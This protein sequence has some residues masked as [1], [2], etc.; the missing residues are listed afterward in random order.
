MR[1][2]SLY[3]RAVFENVANGTGHTV[4]NACAGS[5]K[6]LGLGT[7]VMLH[8]GSIKPVEQIAAGDSLMGPD[9]EPRIVQ[10]VSRGNGP[11]FRIVPVKGDPWICNDAHILTLTGTNRHVNEVRDVALCDLLAE[12]GERRID[13]DWKLWRT[14]VRF[15]SQAVTVDPY[16]VGLWLGDGTRGEAQITNREPEIISYCQ[17]IAAKYGHECVLRPDESHNTVNIRFRIGERGEAGRH[18]PSVLRR[19][20]SERCE[21]SGYK[22]MPREYVFNDEQVRF[23]ILAGLLDTDGYYAGG[24]YEWVTVSHTLAEQMLFL[25]R[26]LGLAAYAFDKTVNGVVYKRLSISGDLSR[27]PVRVPRRMV[28]SRKQIKRATVT[29]FTVEYIGRGDYYGFTLDGDGRFLL[30]DFTVTHNTT[31][32]EAA[33]E[34]VPSGLKTLFVAFNKAIA[35]ELGRRVRG[36]GV[37]VSTLHSYGL[38]CVTAALG[39]LR[40]DGRR[41]DDFCRA[42]HGDDSKTWELRRDLAKTVSLCKGALASTEE[43]VDEIIDAFGIGSAVNGNRAPF[44]QD[45][46]KLLQQCTGTDDGRIDF[47]DMIWLPVVLDL[48]QRKFDRVFVDETQDLNAAQI[49]MVL[50]AVKADGRIMAVGDPRQAVYRFRGADER[51]FENVKTRLGATELPLSICYRCCKAV[52]RE[53]QEIVPTIEAASDADEGEVR[54]AT[55]KEM[56]RDVQPGD[57][58]LSRTNAPL[59]SLCMGF[60]AED[61]RAA[62]QGRDIGAQLAA[63]VKKSKAQSVESLRSYVEEWAGKECARLAAKHRDTQAVEDRAACLIALSEGLSSVA[64]VVSRIEGLFADTND[65]SRIT[66]STT[67]KAKGLERDRVW[68]LSATYRRRPGVEEDNLAYVAMTR[69]RKVLVLVEGLK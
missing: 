63:F 53:A 55:Y 2:W 52:I 45:V 58:V 43:Q 32:I 47:D 65:G 22:V 57:F 25:C 48:P 24:S 17:T 15:A 60:L 61:R 23:A 66:L 6:C 30:G 42:L 27:I 5:G 28:P 56:R 20:F 33:V 16:L 34:H 69:A 37:E 14:G 31:T 46:L 7:A 4:L 18:T 26:S 62:I 21:L 49:E 12:A 1:N 44:I 51:A 3:Q 35:E 9:S 8:D 36:R 29:G 68:M 67:H 41:V 54:S 40:I 59:I 19:F 64:D 38:K 13:R 11:L 50:R 39:R 10:S